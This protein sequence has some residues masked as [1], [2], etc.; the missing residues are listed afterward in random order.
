MLIYFFSTFMLYKC[1]DIEFLIYNL[2][3]NNEI[4]LVIDE[5]YGYFVI[6]T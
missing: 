3:L 5:I 1:I 6:Y 4:L 2:T